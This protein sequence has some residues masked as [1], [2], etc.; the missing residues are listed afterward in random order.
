M[1]QF[2]HECDLAPVWCGFPSECFHSYKKADER[3]DWY[4]SLSDSL[5]KEDFCC[6]EFAL[7]GFVVKLNFM[8]AAAV[9]LRRQFS[10]FGYLSDFYI[11]SFEFM[12]ESH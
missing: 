11:S 12:R 1:Y 7:S 5:I 8:P 2:F 4:I 3:P 10:M 6:E 9:I